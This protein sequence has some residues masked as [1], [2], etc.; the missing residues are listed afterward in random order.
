MK[1]KAPKL[2]TLDTKWSKLVRARA[3]NRCEYCGSDYCIQSHH[4]FSRRNHR[5]RWNL[6]NGVALCAKHHTFSSEFSAHLTPVEFVEWI[7]EKRGIEWY[8]SLREQ[9][10][11]CEKVDRVEMNEWLNQ[12]VKEIS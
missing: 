8:E 1:K 10:R 2:S 7:K 9:N 4:I 11:S 6:D 12:K 3:N 5:M